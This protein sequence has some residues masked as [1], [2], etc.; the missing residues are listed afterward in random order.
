VRN[1]KRM[2]QEAVGRPG[3]QR[4]PGPGHHRHGQPQAQELS[5]LLK[6]Q[7]GP[8][9]ARTCSASALTTRA[10]SVIVVGPELKL[11]EC[12]LPKRMSLE[13]FKPFVM[14]ELVNKGYTTNI[15]SAKRMVERRASNAVWD[16]LD[17]GH[18]RPSGCC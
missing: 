18:P 16:V 8:V 2:L 15:K 12:G 7:A 6:G 4:P 10:R 13:L 14:R 11:H 5:D 9:S 1:E 17:G 3:G